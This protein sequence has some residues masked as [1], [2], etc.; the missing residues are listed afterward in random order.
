MALFLLFAI[1]Q[2]KA[3]SSKFRNIGLYA[4]AY[5]SLN[6]KKLYLWSLGLLFFLLAACSTTP[7][8]DKT[9]K[10]RLAQDPESLHP[11]SYGNAYALQILNLL[12]QS[13]LT[14]DIADQSIKPLL[15]QDLPSV[16]INDSLSSFTFRLR[17]EARWENGTPITAHD[18]AFSLKLLQGPFLENERWRAQF[19]FIEDIIYSPDSLQQFTL[20]CR[21]YTPEM[22]LMAGDFFILPSYHFDPEG[23]IKDIPYQIVRSK[24]DSVEQ[25]P[26]FKS[27]AEKINSAFFAR[28]TAG[29]KGSGPYKLT[30]WRNGQHVMLEQKPNWWGSRVSPQPHV[31]KVNPEGILYQ[32]IPDNAAAVLAL[33]AQQVDLMDDI[34]LVSFL[35]M[36]K[37]DDLQEKFNFFSPTTYDLVYLGMNGASP[38]FQDKQTRQAI[39]HLCNIPQMIQT[40]QGGYATP[41]A[42]VIHPKEK[43]F[44]HPTLLPVAY[45]TVK[46][47]QL[48]QKAGW[49]KSEEGW[50][51]SLNGERIRLELSLLY[52]AGNSDFENMALLFQQNAR[53]LGIPVQIQA[54]ESGQINERLKN[55]QFN[56]FI[57][58]LSGNPFSYNFVPLW[59]RAYAGK[60]GNNVTSFGTPETDALLENIAKEEN[61]NTKYSMLQELQVKM[62]E[63]GNLVFLYFLHNKLAISK[64]IASPVVSSLKPGYDVTKF[65]FK[66]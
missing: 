58:T 26:H 66:N 22:R 47:R 25:L 14:V 21:G 20:V 11:L 60:S 7:S 62:Q 4:D 35:E 63:E 54:L 32:I 45:D 19:D 33:K 13:L 17:P 23:L 10:I 50:S 52:R 30:S 37:Q 59:H 61:L 38:L 24:Y 41:T 16:V 53:Q 2:S 6:M 31:L 56:L 43:A 40:L 46:A 39:S 3:Y 1:R 9:V 57:R 64:R 36:Q 34:P 65:E 48:L 5:I 27:L 44:Y 18:V 49:K 12:Y 8:S 42:G 28:D 29:V 15:S 51:R 55:Q